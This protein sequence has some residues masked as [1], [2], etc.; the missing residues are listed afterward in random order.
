M[1]V[2]SEVVL[3]CEGNNNAGA[4]DMLCQRFL[5]TSMTQVLSQTRTNHVCGS[6]YVCVELVLCS[7]TPNLDTRKLRSI[8]F[9]DP[10]VVELKKSVPKKKSG[11]SW[12]F[13]CQQ[14]NLAISG[15]ESNEETCRTPDTRRTK[16]ACIVQADESTRKRS[17]RTLHKDHEH[18]TASC[19][20]R[21]SHFGSSHF[22]FEPRKEGKTVH[23]A[24]LLDICHLKNS[25][26][27]PKVQKYKGR[28]VLRG[29]I[30]K[31]DSVSYAVFTE[32]GSS[33]SQMTA[34]KIMDIISRLPGC[35][36][37][38]AETVS[39]L[40]PSKN[41]RCSQIVENSQIGVSRQLNSSTTTRMA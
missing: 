14:H 27:E 31:D 15:E 1:H 33:A 13:R 3:K 41:G 38:A 25:E 22:L 28:V 34:A 4:C 21:S 37:Q 6:A 30:V 9:I 17:E 40:Y 35:D 29:D 10:A 24:S 26:L 32:Q 16:Y 12:K 11:G 39:V 18:H 20:F 7:Q 2:E 8:C 5:L 36:G 19:A 23:F